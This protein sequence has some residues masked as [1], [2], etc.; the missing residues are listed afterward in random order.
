MK[1]VC[2]MV[3]P[4]RRKPVT[5]ARRGAPQ[6]IDCDRLWDTALRPTLEDLGYLP[7]RAD[8]DPGAVIVKDMLNRL[9]HADLVVADIGQPNG[10]I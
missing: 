10:N 9:K 8:I 2:F 1:P 4:F 5:Q 3:M 6:E 7:V